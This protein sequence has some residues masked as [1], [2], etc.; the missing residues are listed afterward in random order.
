MNSIKLMREML[1]DPCTTNWE[2]CEL[3][4]TSHADW[5]NGERTAGSRT[6]DAR[7]APSHL[8]LNRLF[9][10]GWRIVPQRF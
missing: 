8:D 6:R 1:A 2:A 5:D 10:H 7:D 9:D 3:S 4:G